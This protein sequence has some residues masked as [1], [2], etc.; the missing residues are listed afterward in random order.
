MEPN[1]AYT[2][3]VKRNKAYEKISISI[4]GQLQTIALKPNKAYES[5]TNNPIIIYE[6]VV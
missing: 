5:V 6:E 3:V 4:P 1:E 2:C